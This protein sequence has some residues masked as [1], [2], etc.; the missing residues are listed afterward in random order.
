MLAQAGLKLSGIFHFLSS[1]W[2]RTEKNTIFLL[3]L[4][5]YSGG[6][7]VILF[8]MFLF[9]ALK[10]HFVSLSKCVCVGGGGM[11]QGSQTDSRCS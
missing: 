10:F 1:H 3:Q 7:I 2:K 4:I 6:Q 9:F 11:L 5:L 8:V